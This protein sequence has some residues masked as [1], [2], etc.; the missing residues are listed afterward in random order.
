M[1][2]PKWRRLNRIFRE[3]G[4]TLI[5]AMDH[6]G[7]SD[8]PL[9]GLDQPQETIRQVLAG[10]ADAIMTTYGTAQMFLP[11]IGRGALILS[12]PSDPPIVTGA[13][14]NALRLGADAVKTM[15]Y[16]WANDDS[17]TNCAVLA[18]ACTRWG[19][20]LLAET[21]PGGFSAGEEMRSVEKIAGGARV[22]VEAGADFIKTFFIGSKDG[23]RRVIDNCPVPVVVLG[24]EK[25]SDEREL[26]TTVYD[27]I[28]AG[29]AGV[30][31]GRNIWGHPQPQKI[32]AAIAAVIHDRASVDQALRI[33]K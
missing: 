19:M 12:V 2:D 10:G 27:A 29:A 25:A 18:A 30:A 17:V 16:P 22:G 33:L 15:V 5:V 14:E 13:V 28:S 9:P 20:P 3:D 11:A 23:F 26:L 8:K 21:I 4:K 1:T 32:T 24:G 31:M 6:V 7:Y